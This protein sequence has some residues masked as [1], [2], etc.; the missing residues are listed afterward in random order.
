MGGDCDGAKLLLPVGCM[1]R[2]T[3][4]EAMREVEIKKTVMFPPRDS[5]VSETTVGGSA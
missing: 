1:P 4:Q 5:R 2:V 3:R